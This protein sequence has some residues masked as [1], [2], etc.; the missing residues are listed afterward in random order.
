MNRKHLYEPP[1]GKELLL[2]VDTTFCA[3]YTGPQV[4]GDYDVT[5]NFADIDEVDISSLWDN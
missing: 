5:K 1:E 3:S 4:T 2:K